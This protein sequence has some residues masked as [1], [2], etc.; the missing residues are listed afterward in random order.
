MKFVEGTR[1]LQHLTK[2]GI[3]KKDLSLLVNEMIPIKCEVPSKPV[4]SETSHPPLVF[5]K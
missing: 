4:V 3:K 5:R 2:A 1:N